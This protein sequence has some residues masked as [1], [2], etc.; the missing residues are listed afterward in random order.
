MDDEKETGVVS[1]ATVEAAYAE[2]PTSGDVGFPAPEEAKFEAVSP[3]LNTSI[4]VKLEEVEFLRY[5]LL[6]AKVQRSQ[7]LLDMYR[8][9]V[10]RAEAELNEHGRNIGQH[11]RAL[12]EK[13]SVDLRAMMVSDDGYFMPRPQ[14]Q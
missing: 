8:R 4:P 5:Q 3:T 10:T 12:A 9:E 6:L 13:Y 1:S 2:V 14:Q 7:L 11:T